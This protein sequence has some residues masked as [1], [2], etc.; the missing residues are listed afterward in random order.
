MLFRTALM[1]TALSLTGACA[2]SS[3]PAPQ[4]LADAP[5]LSESR[6][7][8]I[9]QLNH[10]ASIFIDA[11]NLYAQAAELPDDNGSRVPASLKALATAR[12][13]IA[14]E[15]Q[16]RV[17]ALGGEADT[18]GEALGSGHVA[19]T[20]LRTAIDNDT[21]VAVEEAIRGETYIRDEI[22]KALQTSMT[23]D[24]KAMLQRV[25]AQVKADLASLQK[26][27]REV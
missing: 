3:D 11:N 27:D 15:L 1:V 2:M 13:E 10:L 4:R 14:T 23:A 26:L 18:M 17:V 7:E 22:D 25:S 8:E 12:E 21:E 19:F 6:T 24:S 16:E 20:Y 5:A 9:G